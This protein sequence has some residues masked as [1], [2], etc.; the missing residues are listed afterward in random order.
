MANSSPAATSR[1][2]ALTPGIWNVDTAH[3][4]IGFV[5]RHLMIAKV[6]GRFAS[7]SGIITVPEERLATTLTATVDMASISTGDDQRDAHL[8]S[9]DFFDV[10]KY[11]T[12]TLVSTSITPGGDDF[13]LNGD[14]TIRDVT[15]PVLFN[16]EFEGVSPDPWGGTRAGFTA[17][18][19]VNR[20]DWGLEWNVSLEAG[21]WLVSDKAKIELEIEAVK[22]S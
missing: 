9:P 14:L 17:S 7:F 8:K 12:M 21:G 10:E 3:S 5:A 19:D 15:R 20:K 11:P 22:A 1:L 6:R 18:A 13:L 2:N 16:L 4:T